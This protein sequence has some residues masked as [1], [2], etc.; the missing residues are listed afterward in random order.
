M[1]GRDS[2]RVDSARSEVGA[3]LGVVSDLAEPGAPEELIRDATALG[4]VACLVNNVGHAYQATFEG[5][6]TA[7]GT[8]CGSSTS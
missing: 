4:P 8:R 6:P 3:A 5:S 1:S 7:S 2:D